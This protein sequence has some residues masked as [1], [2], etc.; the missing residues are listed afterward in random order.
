MLLKDPYGKK[1]T[2]VIDIF[3]CLNKQYAEIGSRHQNQNDYDYDY[4]YLKNLN[5]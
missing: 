5:D 3:E 1:L 4:D 2:D